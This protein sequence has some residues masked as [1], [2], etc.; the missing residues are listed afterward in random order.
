MFKFIYHYFLVKRG[1]N[2]NDLRSKLQK[3]LKNHS[4]AE[5]DQVKFMM[6]KFDMETDEDVLN[7]L[8][9]S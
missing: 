6:P 8:F 1:K 3:S 7:R 4:V 9:F 5:D 2:E